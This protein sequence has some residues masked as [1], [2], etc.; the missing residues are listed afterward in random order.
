[1]QQILIAIALMIVSAV[2]STLLAKRPTDAQPSTLG[3]FN[4]P[5]IVEGTPQTVIFGD[6]WVTSWQVLWYGNLSNEPITADSG[7]K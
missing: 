5:N 6:C 7:K 4:L 1:M 3:D 2:I